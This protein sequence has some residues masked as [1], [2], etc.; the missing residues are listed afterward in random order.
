MM[1]DLWTFPVIVAAGGTLAAAEVMDIG[2]RRELFVDGA[3]IERLSGGAQLR[4]HRPIPREVALVHDQPWEGSGC[5]YFTVFQDEGRYRMYY[6]GAHV[7][8][9]PE[10]YSEPHR[11]VTCYAESPDGIHWTKPELGLF[12]FAGS[13]QNNIVW[14]GIGTH[15]FV[16]FRDTNPNAT[17]EAR[18][19]ALGVG[20]GQHG[21]YAFQSADGIHWSLLS[22]QP[23]ITQGAFD[24]QN[25]A[26]WDSIRG[27]YRAYVR[28]F[29][30][31]RDIR[32]C[33][34]P[35][36]RHWTEPVWLEYQ[37]GRI[38]ELYTNQILP[39]Y[40]APHIFL[41]FP[42]RYVDRGWTESHPYL[43]RWDYRQLRGA[44]SPREGSAV[45]DGMFMSSRDGLH[46]QVWPESFIRPGLRTRDN[47]FYG[48]NY[49]NWGLV[50]TRSS[51]DDAPNELSIYVSERAAQE[52][53][54]VTRRYT[55]R[56]DGFVSVEAPL[57]GG[58]VLTKPLIFQG[59]RLTLN[60]STSAAGSLRVELQQPYGA[61]IPGFALEDCPVI[62]GDDL[63][64]TVTWKAGPDVSKLAGQPV[65]LRFV[66]QD[67]DLFAFRFGE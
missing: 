8:Y 30:E 29:R 34:S 26:F 9:T 48:D 62:F 1:R 5:G 64:R 33:T 16:P 25:L 24:S 2:S 6:R 23:V 54:V 45:T 49:Q 42:T 61:P 7:V 53:G 57:S 22:D 21:L 20:G 58:E 50:E 40:R 43:P 59:S 65:R 67:A 10:G 13:K 38:S 56:L 37:P 31:G 60:F 44:K 41:G 17:P 32:T 66:L 19:K 14:D 12:E 18:Y 47:W 15:A 63:E 35:D 4:L 52:H 28:D 36:F 27:E 46:F 11:E 55:L 51:F 3:V 39:Y